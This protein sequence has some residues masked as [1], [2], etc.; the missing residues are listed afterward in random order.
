[1]VAAPVVDHVLPVAVFGRQALAAAKLMIG[2]G[3]TFIRVR[4]VIIAAIVCAE[5]LVTA[6]RLAAI[7]AVLIRLAAVVAVLIRLTAT[8]RLLILATVIV[9]I[10]GT[11]GE[12]KTSRGQHHCHD[13]GNKD[14]AGHAGLHFI[15]KHLF[16]SH[17][18]SCALCRSHPGPYRR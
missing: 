12:S 2:T 6:I 10:A 16:A 13:G 7:V 18:S 17:T 8:R 9:A 14:F 4:I 15:G 5:L 11:L 1:M 3:T